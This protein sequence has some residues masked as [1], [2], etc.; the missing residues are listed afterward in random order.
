MIHINSFTIRFLNKIHL[1]LSECYKDSFTKKVRNFITRPIEK[2]FANSNT[3]KVFAGDKILFANTFIYKIYRGFFNLIEKFM[4]F[5]G[6]VFVPLIKDSFF[7]GALPKSL[8][9]FDEIAGIISN[10]MFYSGL[11]TLVIS[12]ALKA[13]LKIPVVLTI[14]GILLS[15]LKGKYMDI[16]KG[17]KVLE[18]FTSFFKLDEGGENWW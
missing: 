16:I 8:E 6:R 14:L 1:F 13:T 15:L 18:F 9:S 11:L 5:L 12:V 10:I 7:L 2:N 4:G 3:R 17:S